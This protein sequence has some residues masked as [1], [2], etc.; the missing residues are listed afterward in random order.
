VI[1][2]LA[3]Q[4]PISL[5]CNL[6]DAPRSSYYYEP[7]AA[8][9]SRI[10]RAIEKIASAFP[11]SGSRRIS[12]QLGRPPYK[13]V[14]NRK[15]V[16]R[17]MKEM[18]IQCRVKKRTVHTTD[19]RHAFPRYPNLV[20]DLKIVRPDQV[21]VVDITYIRLR[22]EFIYLAIVMDVYTRI[23]RGWR[24]GP[25]LGVDLAMGA[26]EMALTKGRPQ[27][28]HSDQGVQ[29]AST[30]Y[31]KRLHDLKVQISMAEVGESAQNG[32]AERVIRTIKE[33]EVYLNEYVD[34]R[35]AR[36]QIGR[37][38]ESVYLKKRIH[39]SLGYLTPA[40]F[41]AAWNRQRKP[42]RKTG[43]KKRIQIASAAGSS[44]DTGKRALDDRP[45]SG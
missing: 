28:H 43:Q 26:L 36:K 45:R 38:I 39:S 3:A 7:L 6:L 24:L 42:R 21:W 12:A 20:Q 29:Y 9:E 27:I 34:L 17:L 33:E 23:I 4:Y 25:G 19:S 11:T 16:R 30:S 31:T 1:D 41:E 18:N 44:R 22:D 5:L 2:K 14:V 32:Y 15:R 35:D 8:D 37:F 10:R 40:E 13:L